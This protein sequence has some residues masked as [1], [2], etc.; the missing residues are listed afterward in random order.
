MHERD[1]LIRTL[2]QRPLARRLLTEPLVLLVAIAALTLSPALLAGALLGDL[3]RGRWRLPWLR[4]AAFLVAYALLQAVGLGLMMGAWLG[5]GWR[6]PE[7]FL[8]A[9]Y[10]AG[11][12]W[13]RLLYGLFR[14]LYGIE[15]RVEG[16]H[17]LDRG[18]ALVFP[19]H[20]SLADTLLPLVLSSPLMRPRFVMKAALKLD[21]VLDV[22]CSR[23][24][25]AFVERG[26]DDTA[27]QLAM[28]R[29]LAADAG[30]RELVILFPEGTRFTPERR[31]RHLARLEERGEQERLARARA[32]TH[33]LPPRTGG[34]LALLERRPDVD[35][36]FCAHAGFEGLTHIQD[37]L[38]GGMIGRCI[39]VRLWRVPAAEI[40][41]DEAGR[42]RWLFEQ[43]LELDRWITSRARL[44]PPSS[45]SPSGS[46]RRA[47]PGPR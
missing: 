8:A 17:H 41:R 15:I 42:R 5:W 19:R 40:P 43:W 18:P 21:P 20:V 47:G 34:P 31:A 32:L 9:N 2:R 7:R 45:S 14:R 4:A 39:E 3:L 25:N 27:A 28:V 11:Q 23:T 13:A 44:S 12:R 1:P 16:A 46:R 30:P 22:L 26:G 38:D 29:S 37:L 36:V 24:P 35:V 10:A 33:T 6:G